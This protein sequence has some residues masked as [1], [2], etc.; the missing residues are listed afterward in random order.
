MVELENITTNLT[1]VIVG[2][3]VLYFSYKTP[4]AF[5]KDQELVCSE[6]VWSRT[7]G[8]HLNKIMRDK[9]TR[10]NHEEFVEQLQT[11]LS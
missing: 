8:K 7:T 6:N 11:L 4:I 2:N 9:K 10:I 3:I 1:C 5:I